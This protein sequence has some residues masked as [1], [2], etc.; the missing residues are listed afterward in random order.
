[1]A[2]ILGSLLPPRNCHWADHVM[3]QQPE[4]WYGTACVC[5]GASYLNASVRK[6][7]SLLIAMRRWQ[8][9]GV[10]THR[11]TS[12]G[13]MVVL[14]LC[15]MMAIAPGNSWTSQARIRLR[16]HE[17]AGASL[18]DGSSSNCNGKPWFVN[19]NYLVLVRVSSD[20]GPCQRHYSHPGGHGNR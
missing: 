15:F 8:R 13:I 19:I 3:R 12:L 18:G 2:L 9:C 16:G 7:A 11:C 1:M 20:H 5:F 4:R 10:G 14:V 6:E 17:I